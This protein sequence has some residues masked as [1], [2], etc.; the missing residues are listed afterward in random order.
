LSKPLPD[1]VER[2]HRHPPCARRFKDSTSY[3][4]W[5]WVAPGEIADAGI[6]FP[7]RMLSKS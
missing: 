5:K 1:P 2:S 3:C 6:G 4:D 7:I